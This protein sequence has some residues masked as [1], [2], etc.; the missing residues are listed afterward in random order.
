MSTRW[1][2]RNVTIKIEEM[3]ETELERTSDAYYIQVTGK[4]RKKLEGTAMRAVSVFW[5]ET[6]VTALT[7]DSGTIRIE[8]QN[9]EVI[10][11]S[12]DE[13]ATTTLERSWA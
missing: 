12:W 9:A 1:N 11:V 8:T 3:E 7:R 6:A 10:G 13:A 4:G 5:D 2:K